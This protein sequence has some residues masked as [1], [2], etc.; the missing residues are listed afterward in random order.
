MHTE[1]KAMMRF[2]LQL[3]FSQQYKWIYKKNL[4]LVLNDSYGCKILFIKEVAKNV[5]VGM[6]E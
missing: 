5:K 6:M 3:Y 4:V 1:I 2:F